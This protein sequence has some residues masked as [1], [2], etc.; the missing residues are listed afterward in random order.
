MALLDICNLSL[1]T[2]NSNLGCGSFLNAPELCDINNI[3]TPKF[4]VPNDFDVS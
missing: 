1:N 2:I 3:E 4:T